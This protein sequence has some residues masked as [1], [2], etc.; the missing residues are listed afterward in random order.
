M[1][2]A[3]TLNGLRT[4]GVDENNADYFKKM[5]EFLRGLEHEWK[6]LELTMD[7][8]GATLI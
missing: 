5:G 4:Y 6:I 7:N 1:P 2:I 8:E 3:T